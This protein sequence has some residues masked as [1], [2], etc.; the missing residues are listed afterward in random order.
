MSTSPACCRAWAIF[1][2]DRVREL[3]PSAWSRQASSPVCL[4]P[5]SVCGRQAVVFVRRLESNEVSPVYLNSG[6]ENRDRFRIQLGMVQLSNPSR[7]CRPDQ[8]D[9]VF[10]SQATPP[11]MLLG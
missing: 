6:P 7:P 1:P 2:A 8:P 10:L 3:T 11:P 9:P 4:K 5:K